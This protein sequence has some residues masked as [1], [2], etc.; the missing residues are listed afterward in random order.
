MVVGRATDNQAQLTIFNDKNNKNNN[1]INNND[2]NDDNAKLWSWDITR[3]DWILVDVRA[4]DN[5]A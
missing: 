2:K 1:N 5:Q 4:K 3:L